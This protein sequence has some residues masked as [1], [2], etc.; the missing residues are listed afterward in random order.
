MALVDFMGTHLPPPGAHKL[1]FD[2][3]TATLDEL[4]E[5]FQQRMDGHLAAAS[6]TRVCGLA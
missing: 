4:Y 5:P 2:Y 3:G 6:Y 1:Y